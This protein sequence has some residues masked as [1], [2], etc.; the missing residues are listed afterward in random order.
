MPLCAKAKYNLFH[1]RT[2]KFLSFKAMIITHLL[3]KAF[4]DP[5][6]FFLSSDILT[7]LKD[8]PAPDTYHR[9]FSYFFMVLCFPRHL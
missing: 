3:Q 5:P 2:P 1:H 8:Q 4:L 9:D 7:C 6:I